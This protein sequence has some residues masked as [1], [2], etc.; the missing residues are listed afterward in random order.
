[1]SVFIIMSY[2]N[3]RV[4]EHRKTLFYFDTQKL[5]KQMLIFHRYGL[6][7]DMT[8]KPH[9]NTRTL[10]RTHSKC[11]QHVRHHSM[12]VISCFSQLILIVYDVCDYE[13]WLCACIHS[14]IHSLHCIWSSYRED[15]MEMEQ[16]FVNDFSNSKNISRI[17]RNMP[18]DMHTH[19]RRITVNF[20]S[21]AFDGHLWSNEIFIFATQKYLHTKIIKKK[22][23]YL[24]FN[25]ELLRA[26]I[27]PANGGTNEMVRISWNALQK[28]NVLMRDSV[29]VWS[30]FEF[31][32]TLFNW[33]AQC[34]I[35]VITSLKDEFS[36]EIC[37]LISIYLSALCVWEIFVHFI[38]QKVYTIHI[39]K[40]TCDEFRA[41]A[42]DS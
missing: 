21:V 30:F 2:C 8:D 20:M 6:C 11:Q 3:N 7:N 24:N 36:I 9:T 32:D 1:M 27:K 35:V 25:T 33:K 10:T 15:G 18:T 5:T 34:G 22:N 42:E 29:I 41:H 4:W 38:I 13:T 19:Y 40:G 23:F 31:I 12:T 26:T 37:C 28:P 16:R 14:F 39:L 17:Q